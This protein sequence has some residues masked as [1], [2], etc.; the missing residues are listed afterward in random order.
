MN[1]IQKFIWLLVVLA[2]L[3]TA[4]AGIRVLA[5]PPPDFA[6]NRQ[7]RVPPDLA[8]KI[9]IGCVFDDN[10]KGACQQTLRAMKGL[11]ETAVP[12]LAMDVLFTRA[13]GLIEDE[14]TRIE[15]LYSHVGPP[16]EDPSSGEVV[17]DRISRLGDWKLTAEDGR[18]FGQ[19]DLAGKIWIADF[20]FTRC[21]T[22]CPAMCKG[23]EA[24]IEKLPNDPRLRFI[25]FS[26]DPD[27]DKPEVLQDYRKIWKEDPRWRFVT[28]MWVYKL[29]YE[30][31]KVEEARPN[32][33]ATPGNEFFHT[34][35][36]YLVDGEGQ[37]RGHYLYDYEE[38]STLPAMADAITRGARAL[39]E[40]PDKVVD[41][42]HDRRLFLVDAQGALRGVYDS[43]EAAAAARDARRLALTPPKL[44]S[45]RSLP[46]LNAVLNFTSFLFLSAGLAFI[47]NRKIGA[48]K[49]A[50]TMALIT[51]LVFLAS[52]VT[53][54]IQ[55]G[56]VKY[57]G[58][59]W[60]RT[61][62]FA[63]LLSHTILAA[64]VAPMA[65]VTVIRAWR[66]TFDRHVA[67]ARWT[68]PVWMYVSLTGILVYLMLYQMT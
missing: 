57:A 12:P 68:L 60:M 25:S 50:M 14:A 46:R 64:I 61:A 66:G 43:T 48:H 28:G 6:W 3:A 38:P 13:S 1:P 16:K 54:H 35:R 8:G 45:V 17:L 10:C 47:L 27:Y 53:Y 51:S 62:Y 21:S 26:V 29:A 20:I 49:V 39:L 42:V 22:A 65:L 19:A 31:F 34:Q 30:G 23:M 4:A 58:T 40:T 18:P 55:A 37:V 33:N 9:W 7:L 2:G 32:P 63:I 36:I 52:Y 24:I 11:Q 56:S 44:V 15:E 41:H 5:G 67:I 59:G